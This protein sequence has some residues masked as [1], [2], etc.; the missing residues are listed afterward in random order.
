MQSNNITLTNNI[1]FLFL[2][3]VIACSYG[4]PTSHLLPNFE[5]YKIILNINKSFLNIKKSFLNINKSFSNIKKSFSNIK[6]SF[7]NIKNCSIFFNIRKEYY[8]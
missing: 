6:N 2:L 7:F 8:N 1:N 3:V 4:K 5:Y